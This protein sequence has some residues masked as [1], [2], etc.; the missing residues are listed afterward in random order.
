ML[1]IKATENGPYM[2]KI[3]IAKVVLISHISMFFL[4]SKY[5]DVAIR[6]TVNKKI[7]PKAIFF[8]PLSMKI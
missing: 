1:H 6:E 8:L 4:Q 7:T 2:L 3:R 5:R